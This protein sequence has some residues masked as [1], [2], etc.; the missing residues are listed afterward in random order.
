MMRN[1][2]I[3]ALTIKTYL[4][5]GEEM[6][7]SPKLMDALKTIGLNLYERRLWVALLAKGASTAGELS[8]IANVPRSRTYDVLQSLAEKGFVMVQAAKPLRYVA[9]PPEE[10]LERAKKK[11]EEDMKEVIKKIETLKSSEF[12]QELKD[13]HKK[14]LKL[15][16]PEE[17]TGALKGNSI[18]QQLNTMFRRALKK[19]NIITTPEDL[20]LIYKSHFDVL[21]E[22]KEKGVEI[23]IATSRS[24]GCSEAIKALST[25]AELRSV[26]QKEV[27]I[28]G[29]I[30][31]VDG[32]ELM[33]G[34]LDTKSIH[35]TQDLVIWSKSEHAAS[36]IFEPLFKVIW[37]HS[38]PIC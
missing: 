7:A 24:E 19:I 22:A 36:S 4:G 25:I 14:G 31:L 33:F 12:M 10:A 28:E 23:K 16:S 32:K 29:K 26:N 20:N 5:F 9:F 15:I 30:V 6:I 21:R 8:E 35:T 3:K 34:L 17:I 27:P 2:N 37:N 1:L 13:I 18:N 11:I 38:K